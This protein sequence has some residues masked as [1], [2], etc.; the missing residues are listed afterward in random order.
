MP[1]A[2]FRRHSAAAE[3]HLPGR[4]FNIEAVAAG[5]CMWV[6]Y[7]RY[8]V[9]ASNGIPYIARHPVPYYIG[10]FVLLTFSAG[11]GWSAIRRRPGF[12]RYAG[13]VVFA[14]TGSLVCSWLWYLMR[15]TI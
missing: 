9:I 3:S 12:G 5:I 11:F 2:M 7:L 4:Q 8:V 1:A 15:V 13:L 14:I 10:E 6:Y